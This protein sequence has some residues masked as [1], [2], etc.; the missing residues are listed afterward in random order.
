MAYTKLR[1]LIYLAI[2][3]QASSVGLTMQDMMTKTE[4]SRATVERMLNG[5]RATRP[6]Y[7]L[8]LEPRASSLE[9]D[10]HLSKRWRIGPS[11]VNQR[12]FHIS[13]NPFLNLSIAGK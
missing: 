9:E 12:F 8:E 1:D 4:R 10:H 7:G 2:E 5:L 11:L 13:P 3:L 6:G